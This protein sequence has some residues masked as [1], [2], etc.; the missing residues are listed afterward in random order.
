MDSGFASR[1]QFT[2]EE[3]ERIA[4][5]AAIL[6]IQMR[7]SPLQ[8]S[9]MPFSL[10]P[11]P[12]PREE[13]LRAMR[14]M[15]LFN[16]LIEAIARN[17][18]WLHEHLEGLD[19]FTSQ[20][21]A[22]SKRCQP[23]SQQLYLG[24]HR[25]DYMLGGD[26]RLQQVEINTISSA[27]GTLAPRTRMLHSW[28]LGCYGDADM[29][30]RNLPENG[31]LEGIV[32]AFYQAW[33]L[34]GGRGVLL[35]VVNE[36]E[37][38]VFDQGFIEV[39]LWEK[40]RIRTIRASFAD[41]SLNFKLEPGT[42]IGNYLDLP[43]SVIYFRAGY[44]PN[45]YQT[46]HDWETR[47][48]L[49]RSTAVKCPCIDYHLAGV[50]K[51]QQLLCSPEHLSR[52]LP[53][54]AEQ[55]EL[56]AF[57]TTIMGL[58]QPLPEHILSE[59]RETPQNWVLKPM[60][61]GGGNNLYDDEVAAAFRDYSAHSDQLKGYILMKKIM[62]KPI[63]VLLVREGK[64]VLLPGQWEL[65]IYGT[66]L[67]TNEQIYLNTAP[68]YLLRTKSASSNEGGVAAGYAV[69]DTPYLV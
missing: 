10:V 9:H 69:L 59:V 7:T 67:S 60:R 16:R 1:R 53:D 18:E 65:G 66:Y 54:P 13:F 48:L 46:A 44:A 45:D 43:V 33:T 41:I 19:E 37:R 30:D 29:D 24:I 12:V 15:P 20:L 61:E 47:E 57:F 68:G 55:R 26:D 5:K 35:M 2:A 25:S 17:P 6:G 50:K 56:Q 62:P 4:E 42:N 32:E 21:L 63:P 38:N 11:S 36:K 27:F 34:Q 64:A 49:E 31:T 51:V 39:S 52:F 14:A 58:D 22:V 28:V 23:P 8:F 3:V 40:H